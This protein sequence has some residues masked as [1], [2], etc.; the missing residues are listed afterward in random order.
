MRYFVHVQL[1]NSRALRILDLSQEFKIANILGFVTNYVT[2]KS[3]R[4]LN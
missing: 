1:L 3:K 4:F 2:K